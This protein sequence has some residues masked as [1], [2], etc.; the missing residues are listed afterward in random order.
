MAYQINCG[1]WEDTGAFVEGALGQVVMAGGGGGEDLDDR[2]RG[3][4]DVVLG[5]LCRVANDQNIGLDDSRRLID[6]FEKLPVHGLV[7]DRRRWRNRVGHAVDQFP[8]LVSGP[9]PVVGISEALIGG[10]RQGHDINSGG[11]DTGIVP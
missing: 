3:A 2:V 10:F 8:A 1:T 7:A 11:A 4:V 6:L 9:L 5:D